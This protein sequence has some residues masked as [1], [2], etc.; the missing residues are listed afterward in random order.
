MNC[1]T[2]SRSAAVGMCVLCQK[3][4]CHECVVKD[5]ARLVCRACLLHDLGGLWSELL[6]I[7]HHVSVDLL[8]LDQQTILPL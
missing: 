6:R 4:V 2:H 5:T 1:F 7:S 3:G 8:G